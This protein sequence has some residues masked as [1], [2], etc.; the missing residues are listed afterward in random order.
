MWTKLVAWRVSARAAFVMLL[1]V[2]AVSA[3]V[4]ASKGSAA[5]FYCNQEVPAGYWCPEYID[6]SATGPRDA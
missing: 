1:A 2:G 3:G 4:L 5:I 6:Y